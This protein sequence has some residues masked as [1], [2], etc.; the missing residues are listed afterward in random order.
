MRVLTNGSGLMD[1]VVDQLQYPNKAHLKRHL[2]NVLANITAGISNMSRVNNTKRGS[3]SS[4]NATADML[5]KSRNDF[6]LGS[7]AIIL[8][9]EIFVIVHGADVDQEALVRVYSKTPPLVKQ[10]NRGVYHTFNPDLTC[11]ALRSEFNKAKPLVLVYNG[12]NRFGSV[13]KA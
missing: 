3:Q 6:L 8:K 11:Q 7:L 9:Q 2:E 5:Q 13:T 10:T 12:F 4:T 1:A